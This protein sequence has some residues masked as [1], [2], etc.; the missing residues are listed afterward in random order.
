MRGL[1]SDRASATS[2]WRTFRRYPAT[3]KAA[4]LLAAVALAG[5]TSTAASAPPPP[6]FNCSSALASMSPLDAGGQIAPLCGATPYP[7]A[8]PDTAAPPN[9][10]APAPAPS[11][12]PAPPASTALHQVSDPG[13]VTGTLA[14]EHCH[15]TGTAPYQLPDPSCTP[16]AYDPRVTAAILCA[17]RY[18]T[19]DYRPPVSETT[20]FKYDQAYPAYG[21]PPGTR[22]ELDHL[23]SLELGGSNDAANLWPETG[24]VPNPKDATENRLHDWVCAATG[25]QAADR[26]SAAQRAIAADW[27][28]ALSVTGA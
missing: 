22:S 24:R 7:S 10:A 6:D 18:T 14:G 26:L 28:T 8:P 17:P 13:Q 3:M 16:G 4:V 19:R 5:C 21:V 27:T 11:S 20:R 23:V 1:V 9:T 15:V 25:A 2:R 12:A